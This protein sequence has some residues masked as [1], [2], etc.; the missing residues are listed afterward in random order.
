MLVGKS[1]CGKKMREGAFKYAKEMFTWKT[2]LNVRRIICR[3][4]RT[5]LA[6]FSGKK[7]KDLNLQLFCIFIA[8]FIL[9]LVW[10]FIKKS[11]IHPQAWEYEDIA[12]NILNGHGFT[13]SHLGG[14]AYRSFIQPLYPFL[15]AAIYFL[16]NHS[17]LAL[18]LTQSFISASICF[19]IFRI[20]ITIF[21]N[22]NIAIFS[23]LLYAFH[24]SLIIYTA[25][26]HPL[27]LDTFF[28]SLTVLAFLKAG[29]DC[30]LNNVIFT[31]IVSGLCI[32]TRST[33]ALFLPIGIIW[34]F[35]IQ[36]DYKRY[37]VK[38]F[39][40][41]LIAFLVI[42]PWTIRNLLVHKQFIFIQTSVGE[43]FWVG[44]NMHA[45]GSCYLLNGKKVLEYVPPEI[46][47]LDEIGQ[48]KA[49]SNEAVHFI[50]MYPRRFLALFFKKIYYFWWFSPQSGMQYPLE[51]LVIYK[52]L[53]SIIILFSVFG[54][55]LAF[56]SKEFRVRQN[57]CLMVL[58]LA[59]ISIAQSL[60]YVEGRHRW[61]IEPIML[62]FA[63]SGAINI[64]KR[65]SKC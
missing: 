51:Y 61:A 57:A 10:I 56:V 24:P 36:G 4:F 54:I 14:V 11:Y 7:S 31:G 33:I 64:I 6:F 32:L 21:D 48:Y 19:I 18:L 45:S 38:Y 44:N 9:R 40:I 50:K 25:E 35:M 28:I 37:V 39:L 8:A 2:R 30:S 62:I 46:Y 20:A 12:T 55:Y 16:T 41:I 63:V 53:Y 5:M 17:Y 15:C 49:F 52:F 3:G 1:G 26:L 47:G 29:K 34:L 43:Q 27:F 42:L 60:F 13:Y 59:S 23:A 58:F 22:K 65:M